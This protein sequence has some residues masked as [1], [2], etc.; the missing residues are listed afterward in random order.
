MNDVLER[1]E[2]RLQRARH[3]LS[4]LQLFERW[5]AFGTPTLVGAVAYGLAIAPDIDLEIDCDE[6]RI[7]D[8]GIRTPT[9]LEAWLEQNP[10]DFLTFWKPRVTDQKSPPFPLSEQQVS[11]YE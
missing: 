9:Q 11:E 4:Q 10:R 7:E 5:R 6:P 3:I 8:G 1:A 2:Q